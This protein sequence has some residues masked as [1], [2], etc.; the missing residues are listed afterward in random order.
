MSS[1]KSPR[2]WLVHRRHFSRNLWPFQFP[3]KLALAIS[4]NPKLFFPLEELIREAKMRLY[5]DIKSPSSHKTIST[6][7]REPQ[8]AHHFGN[9]YCRTARHAHATVDQRCCISGFPSVYELVNVDY[10]SGHEGIP[11]N[12]RHLSNSS[13]NGSTPLS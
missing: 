2:I 3:L 13:V 4:V 5:D 7:E 6:R 12:S 8:G 10:T 1:N 9:A 11:M